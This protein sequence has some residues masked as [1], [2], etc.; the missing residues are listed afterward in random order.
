MTL[1]EQVE[2]EKQFKERW[3]S[4]YRKILLLDQSRGL[5]QEELLNYGQHFLR[6]MK[7]GSQ[8]TYIIEN[9]VD[10]N[11]SFSFIKKIGKDGEELY[12]RLT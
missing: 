6:M 9:P 3:G 12:H 8:D 11:M 4:I 5:T 10:K 2:E 7:I 1:E